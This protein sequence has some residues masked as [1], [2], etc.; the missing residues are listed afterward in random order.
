MS[1]DYPKVLLVGQYFD[2]K[3]GY[4][5]TMI[6]LFK[7]WDIRSIAATAENITEPDFD[8]CKNYYNLGSLELK[9]NFP[10]NLPFSKQKAPSGV[11][12]EEKTKN[13]FVYN[14]TNESKLKKFYN[15]LIRTTGLIHYRKRYKI[16][17][18]FLKWVRE[19]SPD[20]IY[21]QLSSL[22]LIL[23]VADLHKKT[24]IPVALHMM[25][26]WPLTISKKGVFQH[27][28]QK[29][30]NNS[31][32]KLLSKTSVYMSIS[33]A[34]SKEYQSR[35]GYKFLPFHNP[36]D[37][38]FW[39]NHQK[40]NYELNRI[41][42]ILYAGRIGIGIEKSLKEIAEAVK[43]V[44]K[45]LGIN[46]KFVIKTDE[47]PGW[48]N[49]FSC[50]E[51]Q[52]MEPHDKMPE[53]FSK[54]DIL[55]LSLDFSE[56]SIRFTKFS[57]PTKASDYMASGT[58]ILLYASLETAV[59][60]HALNY[61]WAYVVSEKNNELLGKAITHILEKKELRIQLGTTAKEF[62]Q[63]QYDGNYVRAQFRK[64]FTY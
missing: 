26:D 30:I 64:A 18:D 1:S 36:I 46:L 13:T 40:N 28:W 23:F 2:K 21:S 12:S 57:M 14:P 7:H 5:I 27:Y 47:Q 16:S 33:E 54:A 43:T 39:R 34:M 25:D 37:I 45:K 62:A 44:N 55:V 20:Y 32:R 8:I 10:F 15:Y 41:P 31:F 4:G 60:K 11:L 51:V 19:F 9:L 48:S 24:Q 52:K 59:T 35:Y 56:E 50:V 3:P 53:V 17:N 22:D 63:K 38:D 42:T 58:P 49:E 29:R 6:N 61:K